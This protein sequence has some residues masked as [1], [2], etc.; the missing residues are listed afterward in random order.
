MT[1][2]KL[3][4]VFA[5]PEDPSSLVSANFA[6]HALIT[7]AGRFAP[8]NPLTFSFPPNRTA[9]TV[10]SV[11]K[12]FISAIFV[13]SAEGTIAF[14]SATMANFALVNFTPLAIASS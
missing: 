7:I 8:S 3:F 9:A 12:T 6:S 14:K 5:H 11:R 2:I 4:S 13:H 10:G 1:D